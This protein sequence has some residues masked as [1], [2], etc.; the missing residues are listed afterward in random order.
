VFRNLLQLMI[1][2]AHHEIPDTATV[3]IAL[4]SEISD[5]F[6]PPQIPTPSG[7]IL[8]RNIKGVQTTLFTSMIVSLVAAVLYLLA[9]INQFQVFTDMKNLNFSS[10]TELMETATQSD[11][12]IASSYGFYILTLLV[13]SIAFMVWCNRTTKNLNDSGYGTEKGSGWVVGSFFVPIANFFFVFGT[14][15]DLLTGLGKFF[16][17]IST[18]RQKSMKLWW[19]LA[20]AGPIVMR[21][22][23]GMVT[24]ES[25][26]DEYVTAAGVEVLGAAILVVGLVFGVKAFKQLRD[27][28]KTV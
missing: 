19:S 25:S 9:T 28:T 16:P 15:K 26:V 13:V 23:D 1:Q 10:E 6:P 27:D 8:G 12:F 18:E 17:V 11:D 24:D 3:K 14:I 5:S 2:M 4:M 22:S 21:I 7:N 20:I